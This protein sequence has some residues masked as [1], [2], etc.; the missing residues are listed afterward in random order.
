[1]KLRR[2]LY[3]SPFFLLVPLK[4]FA[5]CPLCVVATGIGV[6]IFRWLGVDDIIVGIWV[7][8][9]VF[10]LAILLG[11]F[12]KRKINRKIPSLPIILIFLIFSLFFFYF[13]GFFSVK[14]EMWG[15]P[16]VLLGMIIGGILL[17]ITPHLHK[18]IPYR[19]IIIT[20]FLL[21]IS[22]FIFYLLT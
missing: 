4:T 6:E 10:S 22:S 12:V 20:L 16:K 18:F 9:F 1:M 14:N 5:F 7:G 17:V 3:I 2:I 21:V 13:G 8:A 19:K 11:K 15:I